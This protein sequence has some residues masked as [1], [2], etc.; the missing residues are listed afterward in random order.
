ML[1]SS[2]AAAQLESLPL[3]TVGLG[4]GVGT[5]SP[6]PQPTEDHS[7][8]SPLHSYMPSPSV[9]ITEWVICLSRRENPLGFLSKKVLGIRLAAKR[10]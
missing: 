3:G 10:L 6:L 9:S 8:L 5:D 4:E 1:C 7:S 2:K